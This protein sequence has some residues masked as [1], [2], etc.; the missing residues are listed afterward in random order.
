M[1]HDTEHHIDELFARLNDVSQREILKAAHLP[2]ELLRFPRESKQYRAALSELLAQHRHML[3]PLI[4]RIR[5][6][7][8]PDIELLVRDGDLR[9]GEPMRVK[10]V[11]IRLSMNMEDIPFEER[12]LSSGGILLTDLAASS[13]ALTETFLAISAASRPLG[14]ILEPPE[15]VV[16]KGSVKVS[17]GSGLFGA[18]IGLLT[19]AGES[20]IAPPLPMLLGG[21]TLTAVGLIDQ[22]LEW[23]KN[24]SERAKNKAETRKMQSEE[25]SPDQ[26]SFPH[27]SLVPREIVQE[28]AQRWGL[29]EECANHILNRCLA[30]Y[31]ELQTHFSEIKIEILVDDPVRST[32]LQTP[33]QKSLTGFIDT[34]SDGSH[35]PEMVVIPAGT[36][37]M[38]DI[39]DDGSEAEK[40]LHSVS[41]NKPFAMGKY[42][43]TFEEYDRFAHAMNRDLPDDNGW[44]RG[45]RPVVNV[46][47]EDAR[48]YAE[49]LSKETGK[50]YRLPYE[51]EW[52][53]AARAG[54]TT[55]YWW[56]NEIKQDGKVWANCAGCGSRWDSEGT[57]PV[58]SFDPNRF[59]LHDML[60][61]VWE[62]MEDCWHENYEGA[63]NDGSAWTS[64]G[65]CDRRSLRGGSWDNFPRDVR[66]ALRFRT[67][68]SRRS[69]DIGFRVAQDL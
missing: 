56:G 28:E 48:A 3:V 21:A 69:Y 50:H 20:L 19:F 34:L 4:L 68:P 25:K 66:S 46:S 65:D 41:I 43:I 27:A 11:T 10:G 14:Q 12:E 36:F 42:P 22:W 6:W 54:T 24:L 52:E 55:T 51:A 13:A 32:G 57:A 60:G 35:G 37:R 47:W 64:G 44:G 45:N 7:P 62:W 29:T 26:G 53:Y 39:Q 18:G 31:Y 49:W 23:K 59:G 40:P 67:A 17:L 2:D 38:G 16:S 9:I 30:R 61:N 1:S 58:G 33:K 15:V 63:P 8:D 5:D